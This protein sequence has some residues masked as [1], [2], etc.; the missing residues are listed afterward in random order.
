MGRIKEWKRSGEEN[1]VDRDGKENRER[2]RKGK[3]IIEK[4]NELKEKTRSK[5]RREG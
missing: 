4:R 1:K 2:E 5:K 3:R